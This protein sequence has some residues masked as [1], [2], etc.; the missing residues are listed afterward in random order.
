MAAVLTACGGGGGDAATVAVAPAA[1]PTTIAAVAIATPTATPGVT[2]ADAG[3]AGN[4]PTL[5]FTNV[6]GT[7]TQNV[8]ISG[9][10]ATSVMTFTSP[11]FT[12][13]GATSNSP[14]WS[15]NGG[16]TKANGNVLVYCSAGQT[17][18]ST[19]SST[20]VPYQQG[21]NVFISA[22]LTAVSDVVVLLGNTYTEFDCAGSTVTSKF[23]ADGTVTRTNSDGT[24]NTLT[25][26]QV[27]QFF[28][29][30][31][32][33][34]GGGSN[35]KSRAYKYTIAAGTRYF[36]STIVTQVNPTANF[37]TLGY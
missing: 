12:L 16:M 28:S 26:A 27:A 37:V 33:T 31:G 6:G 29:A 13:T 21:A 2:P 9:A 30:S 10:G 34:G 24:V 1:A 25:A 3:I 18:F 4:L 22:N 17:A 8:S 7:S 36:I 15:T 5:A 14:A 32:F 19:N 20:L 11:A 35:Y 23:N